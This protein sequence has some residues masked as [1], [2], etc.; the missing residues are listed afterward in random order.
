MDLDIH[1]YEQLRDLKY[2]WGQRFTGWTLNTDGFN[3]A[4]F[5]RVPP[6][7]KMK[8]KWVKAEPANIF[9]NEV[10]IPAGKEVLTFHFKRAG[11]LV[12]P[13]S[14]DFFD[15]SREEIKKSLLTFPDYFAIINSVTEGNFNLD[16]LSKDPIIEV[17]R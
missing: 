15:R 16:K 7:F 2:F 6:Y 11:A 3:N 12:W 14:S 4:I 8:N 9:F 5:I 17:W 10:R 13:S 1:L